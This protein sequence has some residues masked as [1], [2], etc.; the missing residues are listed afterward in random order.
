[1]RENKDKN[2]KEKLRKKVLY[3]MRMMAVDIIHI[4]K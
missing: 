3:D 4:I 1:M 2:Q